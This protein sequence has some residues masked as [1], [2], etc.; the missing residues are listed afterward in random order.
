MNKS[1]KRGFTAVLLGTLMVQGGLPAFAADAPTAVV[2]VPTSN[3]G[4]TQDIRAA[5]KSV[6]VETTAQGLQLSA[7]VR[8]YN[9]GASQNRV[10]EHELRL[11]TTDGIEYTLKPSAGNKTSLQ[12]KEVSELIYMVV[13]DSKDQIK[14][15]QLSFVDVDL[16]TYP[17]KET[18]LLNIP[19]S[20][21][22]WYKTGGNFGAQSEPLAWGQAFTIPGVNSGL[23][24]TPVSMS[25]QTSANG[26]VR[27]VTLLVENPGYGR[28]T[29]PGFVVDALA[30]QKM[31]NGTRSQGDVTALEPGEKQYIH[32]AIPVETGVTVSSLL[33][34]T[35]DNF[36]PNAAA[37]TT[38]QAVTVQSGKLNITA[39]EGK[40]TD[41]LSATSYLIGT[42][43]AFDP[44]A[45]AIDAKT[46]VSVVELH[47][48]ENP[49][50]GY[51]T[52]VAKF[53]LTNTSDQPVPMPDFQTQLTAG[54]GVTYSGTRQ[55]K[56]SPTLDPGLSYVVSYSFNL[57]QSETGENLT[58]KILDAKAAAPYTTTIAALQT[59]AQKE[60]TAL[61]TFSL[62]PYD[63]KLNDYSVSYTTMVG[64][65]ITYTYKIK[66]DMDIKQKE[67]VVVDDNFS[68]LRFE[69]VDPAGRIV[70][71]T[72]AA[73]T[74]QKK[75]ISGEQTIDAS[76]IKSDEFSS[77]ITV[78]IYEVI[79]TPNGEAKRLLKT[80]KQ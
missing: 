15:D 29:I 21:Q 67:N 9:G 28:E 27:V 12:P 80:F 14:V 73:F 30:D 62:Y 44:L 75:L 51:K 24:Y 5:V 19:L 48:H 47:L 26:P 38:A 61:D 68:K 7:V 49:E 13:I 50:S 1:W 63:I 78:N 64:N 54:N 33:V 23:T 31:Y 72:D 41:A 22:V 36:V 58:V 65:P 8:L 6:S 56:V 11:R 66:L 59:A 2:S 46:Q 71:T 55:T 35:T 10:P 45:K 4:L 76:N 77:P 53:R 3:Y 32:F 39:P 42:P 57:P 60:D 16:Y 18:Y 43:I 52:G 70:G 79:T 40:Q 20:T 25:E 37:G 34:A 74:G 17:K 69:I